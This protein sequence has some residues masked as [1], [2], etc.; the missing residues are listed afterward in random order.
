MEVIIP[1]KNQRYIPDYLID[2][3]ENDP[4]F[5]PEIRMNNLEDAYHAI[6]KKVY[7]ASDNNSNNTNDKKDD[8]SDISSLVE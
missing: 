2:F 3:I 1:F 5:V 4:T 8:E 7:G 6:H